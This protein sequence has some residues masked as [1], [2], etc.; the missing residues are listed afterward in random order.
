MVDIL[1]QLLILLLVAGLVYWVITIIP[2]PPLVRQIAI[3]IRVV[4]VA[5]FVILQVLAPL[6]HGVSRGGS[7]RGDVVAPVERMV[8]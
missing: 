2:L 7:L 4:V 5:L 1:I 6:L 3:V 8:G